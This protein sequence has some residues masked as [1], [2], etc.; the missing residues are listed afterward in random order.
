[1]NAL[2]AINMI[3]QPGVDATRQDISRVLM[4]VK[5]LRKSFGGQVVLDGVDMD[6]RE[7]EVVLLR[8][9]N[10]SGK[11]T[12][13]NILTG[14]MEPDAGEIDLFVNSHPEHFR[15]PRRWWQEINPW[16]HFTPERV[17]A[18]GVG[19]TWQDVRLFGSQTLLDNLAV[20]R[21][22][23][24]GEK[25]WRMF[26]PFSKWRQAES[27]NQHDVSGLLETLN[28]GD[29]GDSSA[30]MISL[31]QTKRIA[32]ARSARANS[33]I[34]FLDEP[35]AGLDQ[36]GTKSVID[37][38]RDLAAAHRL[39]LVIVEHVFNIPII[40][41][42]A[43][44]VWTLADG[45]LARETVAEAKNDQA[46]LNTNDL[47]TLIR[48]VA[49][50]N[51]VITEEPLPRGARLTR[52]ALPST[53]KEPLL[54]IKDLMVRRGHRLVVGEEKD[55]AA[56]GL[57][58]TVHKGELIFIQAP[59]GWG[60]TSLLEALAGILP[61]KEGNIELDGL[62]LERQTIWERRLSGLAVVPAR[63]NVFNSLTVAEYRRIS[64]G[65]GRALTPA[66]TTGKPQSE[67][68]DLRSRMMSSL[69][70][71]ER[72]RLVLGSAN[73]ESAKVRI[74]DEP[75]GSLDGKAS[76]SIA[77]FVL[78]GNETACIVLLPSTQK[79]P[80]GNMND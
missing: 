14:N 63:D 50:P 40:L 30:D 3:A 26:A 37:L 49:G 78:P 35:L 46:A 54:K 48:R 59:N 56:T 39:T 68:C 52:V 42:F 76:E 57:N 2:T 74:W 17:A 73:Y 62:P 32:F 47:T 9:E 11:T 65:N 6:L 60:K 44:A 13:L 19:R 15:F 7:G 34:I 71:G 29:R 67:I 36:E 72:K 41:D 66:V 28:L 22:N 33:K 70:G 31:G 61:T 23:Q 55:G 64:G 77:K 79:E 43:T 25:P 24:P 12:L 21:P 1:M 20:A 80:V 38:L 69:S 27:V 18:E 51:A 58:L 53:S 45:H 10:G 8:G 16:D 5:G 75:F 4:Q